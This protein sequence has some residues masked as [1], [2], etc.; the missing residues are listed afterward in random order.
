MC[1]LQDDRAHCKNAGWYAMLS[2]RKNNNSQITYEC[3]LC[4]Q[5][6]PE[7]ISIFLGFLNSLALLYFPFHSIS[8]GSNISTKY[9]L[10]FLLTAYLH[11]KM[12]GCCN[13]AI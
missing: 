5:A 12:L 7:K 13:V 2:S 4:E 3:S 11:D 9:V 1:L 6:A 10:M 8:Y